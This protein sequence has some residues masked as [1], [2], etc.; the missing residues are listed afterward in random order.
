MCHIA[1]RLMK[2]CVEVHYD[3]G[4]QCQPRG[5]ASGETYGNVA[6]QEGIVSQLQFSN[7]LLERSRISHGK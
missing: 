1:G 6:P 7:H 3:S 5:F 2:E 4:A